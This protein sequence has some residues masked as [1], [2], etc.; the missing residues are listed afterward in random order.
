[1]LS[2]GGDVAVSDTVGQ[3]LPDKTDILV[4]GKLAQHIRL[5]KKLKFQSYCDCKKVAEQLKSALFKDFN[6]DKAE[7]W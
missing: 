6:L 4:M 3:F 2:R 5:I 1:M 7:V